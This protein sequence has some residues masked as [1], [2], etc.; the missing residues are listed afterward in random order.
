ME[1]VPPQEI[2]ARLGAFQQKVAELGAVGALVTGKTDRFYLCG[3]T[4][5]AFL[6]VPAR[7]D[8]ELWVI[9]DAA[10]A[11]A[12][13]PVAVGEV[14][15]WRELW[16]R[17][18]RAAGR[19]PVGIA[20]DTFT[21]AEMARLG[22][23]STEEV[24]DVTPALLALR[25]R[26]SP[27]EIA[28]MEETGRMA[29][30]VYAYAAQVLRPGMTE[31]ELGGL[32][33]A[34]AMALGHEGVLRSR[35]SFEPYSWHVLSG[36]NAALPGAV[37]TPMSGTGLSPSFPTG[38]GCRP[39]RR[40]EP[41]LVDFAVCRYGYQTDQTRT[42]CLGPPPEWL[43]EAHEGVLA[44]HGRLTAALRPGVSAGGVFAAGWEAARHSRLSGYLGPPERP[45]RFVGHGVGLETVEPPLI[46]EGARA[47]IEPGMTIA[48]E[49][50]AVREG[51][52]GT[53]VEETF[54]VTEA[55]ARSLFPF[56]PELVVV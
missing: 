39:L 47:P 51:L 2:A 24:V 12:E 9:R 10:R 36:P 19:G 20:A 38:A 46:A 41:V 5:E 30:Q 49:P 52:G 3:T 15:G 25:A 48:L 37:D 27:W 55:G 40:G 45:C 13:S 35:G 34:K 7:G 33:F 6:W 31:A 22:F 11:R 16:E 28:K 44:V 42:F 43:R 1:T 50:K 17:A 29:A 26:K 14:A 54:V 21:V 23:R 4:Q 32:L 8:A 18:R 53:G 56:P